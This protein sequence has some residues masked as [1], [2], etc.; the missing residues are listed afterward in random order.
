MCPPIRTHAWGRI[1]HAPP[2][3]Y[4]VIADVHVGSAHLEGSFQHCAGRGALE[5]PS[6]MDDE[7]GLLQD[8][9]RMTDVSHARMSR[10]VQPALHTLAG[11]PCR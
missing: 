10:S 1:E 4:S 3:V 8:S 5:G 2:G 7:V 11:Q 6:G 9:L